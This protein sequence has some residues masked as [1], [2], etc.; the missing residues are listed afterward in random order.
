MYKSFFDG[1]DTPKSSHANE[2][3]GL[4]KLTLKKNDMVTIEDIEGSLWILTDGRASILT[5]DE[6]GTSNI[7]Q[8]IGRN[9]IITQTMLPQG[10][11]ISYYLHI[12]EDAEFTEIDF[13]TLLHPCEKL[14]R[15]HICI[16]A[17]IIH[18]MNS[19]LSEIYTHSSVVVN[20]TI[21]KKLT[22]YFELQR[23]RSR[24]VKFKIPISMEE[25]AAYLCVDRSA[26]MREIKNMANDGLIISKNRTITI[27]V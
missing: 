15:E 18:M 2:C 7:I 16:M 26:M 11:N 6:D 3:L 20:R 24:S 4:K 13:D 5:N 25:L 8:Y 14:C 9:D 21:R 19:S 22:E 23:Q 17:D 12:I 27:L 1:M 10:R